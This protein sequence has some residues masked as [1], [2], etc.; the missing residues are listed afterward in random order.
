VVRAGAVIRNSVVGLRTLV[1]EGAVIEDTLILGADYY[2]TK[3][4]RGG[5]QA[6]RRGG[7]RAGPADAA[8]AQ[9]L[10]PAAPCVIHPHSG[11][12]APRRPSFLH[13]EA[14]SP[15]PLRRPRPQECTFVPGCQPIGV[16]RN[17]VVTKALIDKNVR[18]GDNVRARSHAA[19]AAPGL[20]SKTITPQAHLAMWS[21][22]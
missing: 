3:E 8:T 12:P 7:Q 20:N 11:A 15:P 4:V 19:L 21:Q 18:I 10:R 13:R 2:E 9:K 6:P 1:Q 14:S 16:G 17:A 5:G 22:P